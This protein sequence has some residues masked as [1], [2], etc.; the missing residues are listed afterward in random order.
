[1]PCPTEPPGF[2]RS[3]ASSTVAW[4]QRV[5]NPIPTSTVVFTGS[6]FSN[7]AP[8]TLFQLG[9][10]TYTNGTSD[11]DS[12]IFGATLTLSAILDGAAPAVD[13]FS[14]V[15]G[16]VTTNNT[17]TDAQNAD[18]VDFRNGLGTTQ[19]VTFNVLEGATATAILSGRIVGD[20]MLVAT[21]IAIA[22]GS[23]GAGFIGP[24]AVPEP[25]SWLLCVPGLLLLARLRARKA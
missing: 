17:G 24:L 22:P 2:A 15:V 4:G 16:L 6:A 25:S 21:Q 13:P 7:V 3:T 5:G 20:P 10:L 14:V 9:T 23:A 12:L 19:P 8:D 1:M 11:L 18:F